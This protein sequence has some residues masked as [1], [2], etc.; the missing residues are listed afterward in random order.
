MASVK[1]SKSSEGDE[2]QKGRRLGFCQM[3]THISSYAWVVMIA[4]RPIAPDEALAERR[5][6]HER[7]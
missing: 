2:T 4:R 1:D 7:K 5:G 6:P 3:E